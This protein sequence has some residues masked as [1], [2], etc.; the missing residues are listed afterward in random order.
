MGEKHTA[1]AVAM[2]GSAHLSL[3]V[4]VVHALMT[5]EDSECSQRGPLL[6]DQ[7]ETISGSLPGGASA[8]HQG[9]DLPLTKDLPLNRPAVQDVAP[10]CERGVS[11]FGHPGATLA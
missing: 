4:Q 2:K 8:T 3:V 7:S 5:R 9:G 6:P 11:R 10:A 1:S